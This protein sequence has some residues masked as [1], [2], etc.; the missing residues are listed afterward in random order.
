MGNRLAIAD[1]YY[2]D[3]RT[4]FD[5]AFNTGS[6]TYVVTD[7]TI[8]YKM[9][10]EFGIYE[11]MRFIPSQLPTNL[12]GISF[13]VISMSRQS[14][15]ITCAFV[16]NS[17]TSLSFGTLGLYANAR[18]SLTGKY[19]IEGKITITFGN[20]PTSTNSISN[21]FNYYI[22]TT[23]SLSSSN[24]TVTNDGI[25]RYGGQVTNNPDLVNM[26]L[27]PFLELSNE[28]D[29]YML[30]IT[31]KKVDNLIS[32]TYDSSQCPNIVDVSMEYGNIILTSNITIPD[33]SIIY[34]FV[35]ASLGIAV[36]IT[37]NET[38]LDNT[39]LQ[40]SIVNNTV[41]GILMEGSFMTISLLILPINGQ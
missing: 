25:I 23:R 5:I 11:E 12:A 41:E 36:N 20:P 24:S 32:L 7:D 31:L 15:T 21:I 39:H 6:I 22:P 14:R 29:E 38:K 17:N 35:D 34:K 3:D 4:L 9:P 10:S 1:I 16:N 37:W 8:I 26:E 2:N 27:L 18:E 13:K 19:V 30:N 33:L 40:L 28:H